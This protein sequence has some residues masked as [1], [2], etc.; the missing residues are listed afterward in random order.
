M[1]LDR[2]TCRILRKTSTTQPGGKPTWTAAVI[3]E[4]YYGELSF[5]TAPARPTE[6]REE[7]ETGTR[8]RILQNRDIRNQDLAELSPFDGTTAKT[9][10]YRILRA[11]HGTDESSGEPISDLTL[12]VAEKT[13]LPVS[14]TQT[15]TQT[16]GD[17][18]TGDENPETGGDEG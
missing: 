11:F 7:T 1:I 16:G 3:H 13:V 8:I 6:R 9:A 12:S 4:S 18:P 14:S 17:T 10:Q 5:E 2:G 15:G